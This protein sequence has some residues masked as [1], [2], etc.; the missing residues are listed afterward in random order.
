[1]INL[2]QDPYQPIR[3]QWNV[4][5]GDKDEKIKPDTRLMKGLVGFPTFSSVKYTKDGLSSFESK[6]DVIM[7]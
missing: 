7:S 3:I 4:S 2:Y 5:S 1:M 6:S